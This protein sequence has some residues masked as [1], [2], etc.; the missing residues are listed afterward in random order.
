MS[1]DICYSSLDPRNRPTCVSCAQA[2]LYGPRLRQASA[3]LD[4]EN[5]HTHAEAIV[6]P[7]NDGV[8]AA[9]PQ[10]ADW[11]A[12]ASG[13]RTV[14]FARH[15]SERRAAELR[16]RTTTEQ[17]EQLRHQLQQH[18]KQI[19]TQKRTNEQRQSE[20]AKGKADLEGRQALVLN[21]S[22]SVVQKTKNRLQRSHDKAADARARLCHSSGWLAGLGQERDQHNRPTG[23][24]VL[25]GLMVP[26]LR[27]LNGLLDNEGSQKKGSKSREPHRSDGEQYCEV[28]ASLDNVCRLVGLWSHYLSINVPAQI[29]MPHNDFPHSAIMPEKSSYKSR[30]LV[31]PGGIPSHSSSP[32]GSRLVQDS[33]S[34]YRP[35]LL[36]LDRPLGQLVKDDF[37]TFGL[38]VEGAM[39]LAWDVAWLCKT[40]GINAINTFDEVCDLGRNLWLLH[41]A[42]ETAAYERRPSDRVVSP[43]GPQS[44]LKMGRPAATVAGVRFGVLTHGSRQ[45]SLAGSEGAAVMRS[46]RLAQS[47]R[48]VDKLRNF[49]L[50]EINGAEWEM[51]SDNDFKEDREDELAFLM[52]GSDRRKILGDRDAA[53]TTEG[54]DKRATGV[55]GWMKVRGRND[56]EQLP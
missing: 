42:S 21:P 10:D 41:R 54:P 15:N 23:R 29:L 26:D 56:D 40:Q 20:L 33:R 1:C 37:K 14:G 45:H 39:L 19:Q 38:F 4:R 55:R 46:W 53:M 3:L 9:L 51:L 27:E 25:S 18:Q 6:R 36:H 31:Y 49:L 50:T 16:I 48:L 44:P 47:H 11:D 13:I 24:I 28:N 32:A 5:L 7:G 43:I 2:L 35:R 8:L 12:I 34:P 17:A 52:G 30:E 22:R